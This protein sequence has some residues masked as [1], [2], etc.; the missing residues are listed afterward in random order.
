MLGAIKPVAAVLFCMMSG[1]TVFA[2]SGSQKGQR[3]PPAATLPAWIVSCSNANSA[4]VFQ[5]ALEQTLFMSASGQRLLAIKL[6]RN[7][8]DRDQIVATLSLPHGILLDAGVTFWLDDGPKSMA[9]ISHADGAGSY[10]TFPFDQKLSDAFRKGKIFRVSA[11][12]LN[13]EDFVFELSLE[14]FSATQ[15][16]MMNGA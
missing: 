7:P 16:I 13:S 15:D 5:C 14:G 6:V 8:S 12:S 3:T 10:A 1:D 4:G 9:T 11:K 2:Q